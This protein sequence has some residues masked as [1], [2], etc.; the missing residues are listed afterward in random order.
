MGFRVRLLSDAS[1]VV[2]TICTKWW[3]CTY[4]VIT[5]HTLWWPYI[6]SGDLTYLVVT[7]R[8][9][10]WPYVPSNDPTYPV[11]T[12]WE[13]LN[14]KSFSFFFINSTKERRLIEIEDVFSPYRRTHTNSYTKIN[15]HRQTHTLTH[16][17]QSSAW[18]KANRALWV[19]VS[20]VVMW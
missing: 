14:V 2:V 8:T 12:I 19:A 13:L 5:L 10:W 1:Y 17:K 20:T 18:T 4:S 7:I 11:V 6:P 15:P 16:T 9:Q 3:P